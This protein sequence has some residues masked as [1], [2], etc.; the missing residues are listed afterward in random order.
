[1]NPLEAMD[2]SQRLL[3]KELQWLEFN[4]R[5]LNEAKDSRTPLLERVHFLSIVTSNLDEF[6]MKRVGGLKHQKQL[7]M[8]T[9]SLDGLSVQEQINR[10][11]VSIQALLD[12]QASIYKELTK[13]LDNHSIIL[14]KWKDLSA[15]EKS[16]AKEYYS[17]QIFPVLTPLMVD[18][19]LPFPFISNLTISLAVA[20]QEGDSEEFQFARV[21]VPE[22]FPQWLN[23][24]IPENKTKNVFV[25]LVQVIQY[26][27]QDLFPDAVVKDVMPFR[28]TRNADLEH[29]EEDAEDLLELIS[30]EIRQRRFADVVRLE[31]GKNSNPWMVQFL[32]DELELEDE[33]I[34]QVKG[35]LDYTSLRPIA[36]LNIPHLRYKH[37]EPQVPQSIAESSGQMFD[38]IKRQDVF[39]HHPYE[40]YPSSVEKFLAQAAQD[41]NVLAIK[42]TLYR[43]GDNNAIV[44]ELIK[45]ADRGKQVVCIVELKA[46]FDEQR[47]I[48]WAQK[49][50]KAGIHVVYGV[51]GYKT[52]CKTTL[53]LRREGSGI[54]AY[55]HIGTGNYNAVTSRIYTDVGLF[56]SNK[57]VTEDLVQLFHLLTGRSFKRTFNT[58]LVS[59]VNMKD[60]FLELI[61]KEKRFAENGRPARIIAKCNSLED[62]EIIESLYEA[63][64]I[65]VHVDLIVRGFCTLRPGVPG[66]SERIRVLSVIGRFLEHSRI[67]YFQNGEDK[68]I[69]GEFYLSSADW[70]HRNLHSRLE[71]AVPIMDRKVKRRL[72][73]I[74]NASLSDYRQVWEMDSSGKYKQRVADGPIGDVGTHERLM[75]L[76][77]L[78]TEFSA[79]PE[80][81]E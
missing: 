72:W 12:E 75:Q 57:K 45:A 64:Q 56:T 16:F 49:M 33:H 9:M 43:M 61:E 59:P 19:A 17:E 52:H 63:S 73:E 1:L 7:N 66:M 25:S 51:I 31:H 8:P 23:I 76:T 44:Q 18:P 13:E 35:L 2:N 27:L 65:G 34:Y 79:V 11:R 67:F 40:S 30:E 26:N 62:K 68:T 78:R 3:N 55:G 50:E 77:S 53:V 38:L 5:V 39:V 81:E 41:P 15:K 6:V 74:L 54:V 22:V 58:L 29:D 32:K 70:M 4:R 46:R 69:D 24:N 47:N 36:G 10:T 28:V 21:K 60:K 71:V 80:E 14:K 42:M 37:W 20:L 48:Y